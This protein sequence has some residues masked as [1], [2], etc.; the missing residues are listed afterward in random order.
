[1]KTMTETQYVDVEFLEFLIKNLVKK[2]EEVKVERKLDERGVLLTLKVA[3]EDMGVVIGRQGATA[4]AI[5]TLVRIV[6]RKNNAHINLKIEEPLEGTGETPARSE[7]SS[8]DQV[9]EDLKS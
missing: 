5:R 9:V 8:L 7:V 1:M 4:N 6:G 2:P 3:P